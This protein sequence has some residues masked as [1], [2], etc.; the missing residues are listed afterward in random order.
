MGHCGAGHGGAGR[1]AV[2]AV[3]AV[4]SVGLHAGD[5]NYSSCF[6]PLHLQC[7]VIESEK[8][9]NELLLYY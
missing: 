4:L 3:A 5:E 8:G 2:V 6:R 7:G 1:A 9:V